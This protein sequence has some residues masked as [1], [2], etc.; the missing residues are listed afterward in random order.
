MPVK[1][2]IFD[3]DGT[4]VDSSV[5]ITNALN[6]ALAPYGFSSLTPGDVI[7]M[8]G[9]GVTRL[10]GKLVGEVEALVKDDVM[11]RFLEHYS[12]HL[13]DNTKEY[14]GVSTTLEGLKEFKKAIISNKRELLSRKTLDGLGLSGFFDV[15]VGSDTTSEK[16]PSPVP[17]LWTLSELKIRPEEA[18][19]VGDSNF[20][21]D[22][23]KAAG[24]TTVAV[25]Y[26]YRPVEAISHADYMIDRMPNLIP[27]MKKIMNS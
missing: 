8:V 24:I 7:K 21:I 1:L 3:L 20:D 4:L 22:A 16:K 23:G 2:I 5:D 13:L 25:T 19:I 27:L 17:V 18:M 6:Y 26:G 15:I 9:E 14:P 10:V 11:A 12:Q